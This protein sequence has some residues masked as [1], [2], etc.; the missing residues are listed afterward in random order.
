M[1]EAAARGDPQQQQTPGWNCSPW[2]GTAEQVG[3]L[4]LEQSIPKDL[5]S[6]VQANIGA[7]LE[8]LYSVGSPRSISLER[9]VELAV[10]DGKV[11]SLFVLLPLVLLPVTRQKRS[12][13]LLLLPLVTKL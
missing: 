7:V 10:G 8:D 1:K 3:G 12:A 4:V 13:P 5:H 11:E 9:T 6:V 2:R